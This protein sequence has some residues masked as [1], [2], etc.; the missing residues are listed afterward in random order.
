MG[1]KNKKKDDEFKKLINCIRFNKERIG[2]ILIDMLYTN[3]QK[4]FPT[5]SSMSRIIELDVLAT[6]TMDKYKKLRKIINEEIK[7]IV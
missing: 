1:H 6:D 4:D 7:D 5:L 2:D 3:P